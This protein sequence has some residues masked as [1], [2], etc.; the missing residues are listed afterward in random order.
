MPV[1]APPRGSHPERWLG[2]A[3]YRKAA[4]LDRR[5]TAPVDHRHPGSPGLSI[6]VEDAPAIVLSCRTA[7]N[8]RNGTTRALIPRTYATTHVV[9]RY[10]QIVQCGRFFRM[11]TTR[12]GNSP[13]RLDRSTQKRRSQT[14]AAALFLASVLIPA[15]AHAVTYAFTPIA[16]A[17]IDPSSHTVVSAASTPIAFRSLA[18]CGTAVPSRMTRS[19]I[20]YRWAS[21]SSSPASSSTASGSCRTVGS[22]SSTRIRQ[23]V[24][25]STTLP[26][27]SARPTRTRFRTRPFLTR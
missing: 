24:P 4:A 2:T 15:V 16:F 5:L 3:R 9:V 12:Q 21:T 18:G 11:P 27:I 1:P 14:A 13:L 17:W 10:R 19:V 23:T 8:G 25:S 22:S 26:A 7:L 6:L 20:R